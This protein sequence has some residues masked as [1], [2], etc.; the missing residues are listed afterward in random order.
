MSPNTSCPLALCCVCCARL[1]LTALK[2]QGPP[3]QCPC[4][5]IGRMLRHRV[6]PCAVD[7][8]EGDMATADSTVAYTQYFLGKK[9]KAR[10][11]F[12]IIINKI[13]KEEDLKVLTVEVD[14]KV[15]KDFNGVNYLNSKV[16]KLRKKDT[17]Y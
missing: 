9:E 8:D 3:V 5:E 14:K 13:S 7:A 4:R 10:K 1:V 11:N 15:Y 12:D 17:D 2:Y 16:S 6:P